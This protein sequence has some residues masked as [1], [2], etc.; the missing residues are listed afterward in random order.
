M[1]PAFAWLAP[2]LALVSAT[3]TL[4]YCLFLFQGYQQLFRDSD[5]GWHIRT[6]EAIL[7]TGTLPRFDP[8][9]FSRPG[10]PWFAWEWGADV[11]VG[12]IHRAGGL[13][14]VALF[15]GVVIAVG[16]L[17]WFRLHWVLGGN[18]LLA[19]AMS[20]LLLST[21]TIHWLARPHVIGWLFLLTALLLAETARATF[22][23]RDAV[24]VAA[25]S[26]LWANLHAS[27]FFAPLIFGMYAVGRYGKK[28]WQW[29]AWA[30]AISLLA[31]LANPYGWRLYQHIFR[32][33]TDSDLLTRIAEF[34]SFDFHTAGAGQIV[35]ALILG[36][37]GGTL[38]FTQRRYEHAL[39]AA[40]VSVLAIRS[41][42]ALP[43]VALLLLP[44]AN[45]AITP[46]LD[47]RIQEFGQ[48]L[49]LIDA[50]FSG[51]VLAPLVVLAAFT[52]LRHLPTGFP[53]DQF[54]VAAYS[55]IPAE[56]RLFASDKFGGYL[57]YRSN[58][59]LKV[60]FDGR[61]DFYGAE[62]LKQYSRLVQVR[63]GWRESWDSFHFTHALLPL[64]YPLIPALEQ[65]GWHQVYR[66]PT[67]AL[68]ARP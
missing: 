43:L 20:P 52:L 53:P 4:F 23:W 45:L 51:L 55:H 35:A 21:C 66:D 42:R 8:Y 44:L 54:P 67:A 7:S 48:G 25:F 17:L 18:F 29:F 65:L 27:F 22:G 68:L 59:S 33:L 26:A 41:A 64:D 39:L 49:R 60:F 9:S 50:R 36:I 32:Y 38:A 62:F 47:K 37:A 28:G 2:D 19:C 34:Q 61:S 11:A 5:A 14:A 56:A 57:I 10:Q 15:Y 30:A 63:P 6:G 46:L 31:P 12:A 1:R 24:V 3:V 58:G 16:V 13:P 40:V